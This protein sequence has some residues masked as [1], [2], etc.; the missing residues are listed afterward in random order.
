MAK[1]TNRKKHDEEIDKEMISKGK[2]VIGDFDETRAWTLPAKTGNKLISIRV[3]IQLLKRLRR[4]ADA[5]GDIGYQT[6]IKIYVA[7]GLR[8]DEQEKISKNLSR[9]EAICQPQRS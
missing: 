7:D 3:P 8:R 6:L 9:S 1:N 5:M 2:D 4:M